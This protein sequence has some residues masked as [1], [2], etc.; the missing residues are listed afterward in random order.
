[1]FVYNSYSRIY[2]L[3]SYKLYIVRTYNTKVN[4][5]AYVFYTYIRYLLQLLLT[6][7]ISNNNNCNISSVSYISF[8]FIFRYVYASM[9][10]GKVMYIYIHPPR[11]TVNIFQKHHHRQYSLFRKSC[12]KLLIMLTGTNT[13]RQGP[14]PL[15]VKFIS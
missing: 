4:L 11:R 8:C 2:L 7:D 13:L 1:M 15:T 5:S 9:Q 12:R 10:I 14:L 6:Y 3:L